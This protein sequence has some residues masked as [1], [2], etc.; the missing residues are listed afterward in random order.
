M[1][2][3]LHEGVSS[4]AA[5]SWAALSQPGELFV[6]HIWLSILE[7]SG[8]VGTHCGWQALP[9]TL[10]QNDALQ[11]VVPV[12]LKSHSRGEYV[13]DWAWAEAYQQAGLDYFPKLIVA[14]PFTPVSGRRLLAAIEQQPALIAGLQ[15][16]VQE[17]NL[18]SA[19]VLF[20]TE[21]EMTVLQAA[22]WL[23][24]HGV[25]FHWRNHG[26][27]DFAAFLASLSGDKRKKIRQERRK[28]DAAGVTVRTMVGH[29]ISDEQWQFFNRCYQQTYVEHRS[30]P[31]LNLAFFRL[32]GQR[33]AQH[34]VLF[35]AY[36]GGEPIAASLC[37]RDGDT[38]FGRYWGSLQ[39]IPCLHFELCYYQGL[40]YAINAGLRN[41]EGGAQGEHKQARGF[42]PMLTYSAHYIVNARFR[43]VLAHWLEHERRHIAS[44]IE[45][46][47]AHS[48]YQPTAIPAPTIP[49]PQAR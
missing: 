22:G 38:L 27:A 32:L 25:Q 12:Y 36:R 15:Q 2:L 9:L 4:L 21:D 5:E 17:N 48:A 16:L 31:Y 7:E 41:F 46:L 26:F 18:S 28:V 44:Y 35:I 19:H 34:C 42:E 49:S 11:G 23:P 47:R 29:E 43:N 20:P 6:S 10:Q 39:S 24:R 40:E 37:L 30:T 3:Q 45:Q 8:C 33:L 14:S 13:F 1:N